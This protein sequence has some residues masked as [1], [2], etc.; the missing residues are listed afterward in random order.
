MLKKILI[1][2][3]A[4]SII[5]LLAML[6]RESR[7]VSAQFYIDYSNYVSALRQG[8]RDYETLADTLSV[9][10][11]QAQTVPE[12]VATLSSRLRS[13]TETLRA[14]AQ[15][16][17]NADVMASASAYISTLNGMLTSVTEFSDAQD[18]IAAAATVLRDDGPAAVRLL[19][20]RDNEAPSQVL[21]GLTAEL[22][23]FA[24]GESTVP[25]EE[26]QRRLDAFSA[27]IDAERQPRALS[28][29]LDAASVLLAERGTA[30]AALSKL[31][32]STYASRAQDLYGAVAS[33]NAAVTSRADRA[34]L[35]LAAVCVLLILGIALIG[36]RLRQSNATL[37][38]ANA[39]LEQFNVSLEERVN[40]RTRELSAALEELRESQAQLVQ[41]EKMSSLGELVAGISHEINTP[42]WYLLSNTTTIRE[43]LGSFN[44]FADI[45]DDM[46]RVVR[47]GGSDKQKFVA[48]LKRLDAA[49][50]KDGLRDDLDECNDL[51]EDSVDGLEQLSEMAQSLKD[52]SRLD[53]AATAQ[54]DL[55]EGLE[56][57]LVIAK[58]A[59]KGGIKIEKN[60]ADL[61][62]VTCS[63]SQINQVFLNLIKNA[64]DSMER[65]GTLTLSSWADDDFVHVS[66]KD[67]GHGMDEATLAKIRDP[68]F[69][70]KE[71]GK[72]TGLGLSISQ[73]IVDSHDGRLDIQSTLGEGS[74]FTLSLPRTESAPMSDMARELAELEAMTGDTMRIEGLVL[75]EENELDFPAEKS[76]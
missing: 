60:F 39:E 73:K 4:A 38:D 16:I 70:T 9:T 54:A 69:T 53:R 71:V 33:M 21:F 40:E 67:S 7:S 72:G 49:L 45:A 20:D 47:E 34:R 13:G 27:E 55:N 31:T 62:L 23:D 76:A 66:V 15:N 22:L 26:L 14:P 12:T 64:S 30:E 3:T 65:D 48:Q 10:A 1:A 11:R 50:H 2:L 8:Q 57:T 52:F 74:T 46:L 5:I 58:N 59:L 75:D 37:A 17:R 41:A 19:R 6:V 42:L 28:G 36:L 25:V 24:S 68:F 63:P 32:G 56:K 44:N 43:R 29:V 35:L 61:P 18:R 51:L